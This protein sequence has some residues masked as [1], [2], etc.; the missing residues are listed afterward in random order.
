M[1]KSFKIVTIAMI[2]ITFSIT[3][4]NQTLGSSET[5]LW[6]M[7]STYTAK[8][9]NIEFTVNVTVTDVNDLYAWQFK[10]GYDPS[11]IL[12][13]CTINEKFSAPLPKNGENYIFVG[14][15]LLGKTPPLSGNVLLA[16]IH[17]KTTAPGEYVFDLFETALLNNS[18][19]KIPHQIV[20]G[21]PNI[22]HDIALLGLASDPSGWIPVPQGDPVYIEVTVENKG[23]F[24]E[25]F[26]L[27]VYADQNV[28]VLFDELIAAQTTI[29]LEPGNISTVK[30]VWDTTDAPY[31]SYYISAKAD[32]ND[33]NA[34]NNFIRA[35]SFVGGICH[36]WDPPQTD[37]TPFLV[38]VASSATI[39]GLLATV[40]IG[41][42][43]ALAMIR[44]PHLMKK[45]F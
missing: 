3:F 20:D 18:K 36:R 33:D 11:L 41:I 38:A 25:T 37:Y 27:Y 2:L 14:G 28:D 40:V 45:Y 30:L 42:F 39:V 15:T 10:L 8:E 34:A 1:K 43:K 26:P 19:E 6:A 16:S 29:S 23:N 13:N 44:M 4:M 35:A 5:I 9:A 12:E 32:I 24:T 7:P 21:V 22:I 31:G 17:F